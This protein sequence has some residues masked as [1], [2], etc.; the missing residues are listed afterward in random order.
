MH[1]NKPAQDAQSEVL[2]LL[3][4][5]GLD[6]IATLRIPTCNEFELFCAMLIRA[7]LSDN[8]T[9]FIVTP[10]ALIS[11][12]LDLQE[13]YALIQKLESKKDIIILDMQ[14]NAT[15]YKGDLCHIIK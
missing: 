15:H 3:H 7:I 11:T 5:I 4:L 6:K 14:N 12:L 2:S 1:H 10:F 8:Q 13:I 9:I